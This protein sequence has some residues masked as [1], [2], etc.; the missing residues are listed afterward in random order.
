MFDI[1]VFQT[2]YNKYNYFKNE[3]RQKCITHQ[4]RNIQPVSADSFVFRGIF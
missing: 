4:F 3:W 2:G 1:L